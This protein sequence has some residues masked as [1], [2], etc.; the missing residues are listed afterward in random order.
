MASSKVIKAALSVSFFA[1]ELVGEVRKVWSAVIDKAS[2]HR[3]YFD[4]D[5]VG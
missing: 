2:L 5:A 3:G 1:G 4:F